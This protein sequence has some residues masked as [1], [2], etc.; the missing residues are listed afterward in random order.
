MMEQL[1]VDSQVDNFAE[2]SRGTALINA[3]AKQKE[4]LHATTSEIIS[5]VNTKIEHETNALQN[6]SKELANQLRTVQSL[7]QQV[8][9]QSKL[10][11]E[12]LH[13]KRQ[14]EQNILTY[15]AEA[16]EEVGAMG[17]IEMKHVRQLPKIRRE[18]SMYAQMTNIKWDYSRVDALAGEVS[19]PKKSVH[20]RFVVEKD[21]G[22]V[23]IADKIWGI[24]EG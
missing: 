17:E 18:I 12:M 16:A 5:S 14:I 4:S 7:E 19:L 21:L 9:E 3:M 11:T 10:A 20:R 13:Q 2:L 6:E 23:E 1:L 22:E 24:M 15:K 8:D